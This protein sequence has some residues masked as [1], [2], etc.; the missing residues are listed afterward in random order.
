MG[1]E[2]YVQLMVTMCQEEQAVYIAIGPEGM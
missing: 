2:R 1:D